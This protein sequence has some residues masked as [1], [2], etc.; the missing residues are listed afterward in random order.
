[1]TVEESS[2]APFW[3]HVAELQR[4]LILSLAT[5]FLGVLLSFFFYQEIFQFITRPFASLHKQGTFFH[6]EM[7]RSR[8]TNSASIEAHYHLQPL[9]RPPSYFSEGVQ[10]IT[11]KE[12]L[13][14]PG[15]F[16]DIEE[17]INAHQLVIFGPIEGM[18]IAL[19]VC[20]WCGIAF[21]SPLW[22]FFL[23][24]FIL[25]ALQPQEHSLILPFLVLSGIF[26][27]LGIT[28]AYFVTIPI[29]NSYLMTFNS[30]VGVNLWSLSNY[31]DYTLFLLLANAVAFELA[32]VLFFLVHLGILR[33]ETMT[34][35]RRHM[36]VAA[37]IIGALL[38]PPDVLTQLMLALPL[39]GLYELILLYA[40][41]VAR[42]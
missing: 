27:T 26:I 21:T 1:M 25:P 11:E 10:Q 36:I 9:Q 16:I 8:V 37:F 34:A 17:P 30:S 15:S 22:A 29:A 33:A 24:R 38:T 6:Q 12:Y 39:I 2:L 5:I 3:D 28:L 14:Q 18:L 41:V 20:F 35:K 7:K 13:L 31:L 42:E 32:V 4:T 40:R 23:L 19:K